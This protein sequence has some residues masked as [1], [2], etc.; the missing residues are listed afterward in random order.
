MRR[1]VNGL[2]L[3][4]WFGGALTL[5][6]ESSLAQE[7]HGLP[8]AEAN[9][10]DT[11]AIEAALDT[12]GTF[13]F[14]DTPLSDV[15]RII[16]DKQ[17]ISVIPDSTALRDANIDLQALVTA[18]LRNVSL[19]TALRVMLG[20]LE[21]AYE[22]EEGS[23]VITTPTKLSRQLS[24]R[25]Y[26]VHDLVAVKALDGDAIHFDTQQLVRLI[27]QTVAPSIRGHIRMLGDAVAVRQT[28]VVNQ[29][30]DV[31]SEVAELL[32][33]LRRLQHQYSRVPKEST[34]IVLTGR[35]GDSS[36]GVA[37]QLNRVIKADYVDTPLIEV[38]KH[39]STELPLPVVVDFKSLEDE[40]IDANHSITVSLLGKANTILRSVLERSGLTCVVDEEFILIT[41][42]LQASQI[43]ETRIYPIYD[44]LGDSVKESAYDELL[45]A[46]QMVDSSGW[47]NSGGSG[48][49]EFWPYPPALVVMQTQATHQNIESMLRALRASHEPAE[50][51]PQTK[52]K[53]DE[54]DVSNTM[55]VYE[56]PSNEKGDLLYDG[57]QVAVV[58]QRE[59]AREFVRV[60]T[61]F[62]VEPVG[63]GRIVVRGDHRVQR[64]AT[65]VLIALGVLRAPTRGI[66][67][68]VGSVSIPSTRPNALR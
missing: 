64:Y 67:P 14:L 45:M 48:S 62:Y 29:T 38:I 18:N 68:V 32:E 27:K 7:I 10:S 53:A 60:P 40:R 52:F 65:K 4:G 41:T 50:A 58:L 13:Q 49:V 57:K 47:V 22:V 23:L 39:V 28:I 54:L 19:R 1:F 51:L 9:S 56:L 34:A 31:H 46:V 8:M 37:D 3:L 17:G 30:Q 24:A 42:S 20:E 21:L 15:L 16:S 59:L 5:M 55:R 43:L 61:I 25:V 63:E 44:V 66:I 12:K 6:P 2:F 33:L 11:G 36:R 26:R 35:R